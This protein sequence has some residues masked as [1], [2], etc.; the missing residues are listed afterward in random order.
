MRPE[1]TL[2]PASATIC[3]ILLATYAALAWAAVST[4]SATFDEPYHAMAGWVQLHRHDF[5]LDNEDPPL[6]LYWASLPNGPHAIS[7]DF[8]SA[9]WRR[10][11]TDVDNQWSWT[12]GTLY[13]TPGNDGLAFV[14][15]CR[16]MMLVVA[17][18]L[19][20]AVAAWAW[21]LGGPAAAVVATALF[22]LDP[23]LL[24][25]GPLM[26]NDVAS[27]LAWLGLAWG[28]WDVGRRVT[29]A[30]VVRLGGLLGFA[31]TVKFSG[32]LAVGVVPIVL[33]ARAI[34]PGAWPIRRGVAASR[35]RRL[36]VA[37]AV[38]AIVAGTAFG[39]V[40]AV[41]GFRYRS[42]PAA[43]DRLDLALMV[44]RAVENE[45]TAAGATTVE[46][47]L[48]VRA[49][50][51]ADRHHLLPE[52]YLNG[53]LFTYGQS[54]VRPAYLLG[55]RSLTGWATYFPLAV[56][57]KTPVATLA[58]VATA[59]AGAVR[60]RR[61]CNPDRRWA[62]IALTLPAGIYF[63]VAI[64]SN[65]NIGLRHVIPVYPPAF[66]ATGWVAAACLG[67]A[68]RRALTVA[69]VLFA[70]LSVEAL[71]SF[72]SYISFFNAPS[73][74]LGRGGFDLLGD[75]NLDWGQDLV[76]LAEWQRRHPSD[77]L[78]LSYFGLADPQAYGLRYESLP[79]GY[80]YDRG[81]RQFSDPGRPCW[82]AV[83]VTNLQGTQQ[84][85]PRL[86]PYYAQ[87][88]SR[89]PDSVLGGSIYLYRYDPSDA[90]RD[91]FRRPGR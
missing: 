67:R 66:I 85:D 37:A 49:A 32:V 78:Y 63:A 5:R 57:F 8:E 82:L 34:L 46:P 21:R 41:Y 54:L 26:K 10:M 65:L 20:A 50:V 55:R 76:A 31:L 19:G 12:V 62:A 16:A 2:R 43:D 3:V 40:W 38:A 14:R 23:N 35:R 72:P 81:R 79:G 60:I 45:R 33:A 56:A 15:R 42:G 39:A 44:D 80:P 91:V 13:R 47:G 53:F 64:R 77:L 59:A 30:S 7:A 83:S 6:W 29:V 58:A 25:H 1:L 11:A 88:A 28:L 9:G 71:L 17:V 22:A 84:R 52:A 86:V 51:F 68:R 74:A 24:A 73:A 70:G 18:G 69:A 36:A 89:T 61:R 48:A 4:K 27:A 90:F 87:L 75:S